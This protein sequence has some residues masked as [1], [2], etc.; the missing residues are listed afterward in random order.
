[1]TDFAA[2]DVEVAVARRIVESERS[3]GR[4]EEGMPMTAETAV[5]SQAPG[6]ATH[7]WKVGS[8]TVTSVVENQTERIPPEFFFP[9]A[10]AVGVGE[11][12]WLVPDFADAEGRIGLRVQAFVIDEPGRRT[13]VDPCVGNG[14]VRRL[15]WFHQQEW[16]FMERFGDAG[17][18]PDSI[19]QVVHTHL[20]ADH[21]GWDTHLDGSGTWIPTF[22]RARHLYTERELDHAASDDG[23]GG[24]GP[25]DLYIDSVAPIVAAG[26]ADVVAEDADLGGSLRLEPAPGHSPGH[27]VL[28]IE[29]DGEAAVLSGDALHHPVQCAQP[30]WGFLDDHDAALA[31]ET[32]RRLLDRVGRHRA[33]LF[34]TH[35]PNRPAGRV[36]VDGDGWRFTPVDA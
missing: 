27:V 23:A 1:V 15:P 18:S 11:H 8:V 14:K 6:A 35:F 36:E 17:F 29:S 19:D 3:R 5:P 26:L 22:T 9:A 34:G 24:P 16:P 4:S 32:R 7:S 12:P 28:W 25:A 2:P 33:L 21:V 20:H 13:L 10:S 30:G 31:L